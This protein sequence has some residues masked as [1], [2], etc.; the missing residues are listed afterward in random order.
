MRNFSIALLII[1]SCFIEVYAQKDST[2]QKIKFEGDFRFRI[3]QDWDSRN[4]DGSYRDDRSRLRYRARAGITYTQN[5]YHSFGLRLRTGNPKKQQ[6]PQLTLGAD[7]QE[8]GTLPIAFEKAY[9]Q[10]EKDFWSFWLGKNT[11]PFE[12][13]NELFWSD[14]VFP[15][16]AFL[17]RKFQ[18]NTNYLSHLDLRAGHFILAANGASFEEDAYL[19]AIQ[20]K[21][22]WWQKKISLFPAFY[23][24]RNIAYTPDGSANFDVDYNIFHLGSRFK[25]LSKPLLFLELDFLQ[26][27]ENYDL[28]SIPSPLQNQ[29]QGIIAAISVGELKNKGNWF[30]KL[31]YTQLERFSAVD[32]LAQN[33]WA[34]WDYSNLASPDGRLTNMEGIE[35]VSSFLVEKNLKLTMKYYW[36]DQLIATGVKR[37]TNQRIR[38]DLD[39]N[40]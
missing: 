1:V 16:G 29:R 6:D 4:P 39:I 32:Y 19:Q 31:T 22:E 25:L 34:R 13:N 10:Y 36:V 2:S 28:D 26:N 21:S 24:F 5:K 37:E 11:F 15:D 9:Y 33:D 35:F 23:H 14:N 27:I 20:I 17:K 18:I 3:E 40:F 7:N 30:F 38:F 12:K 8:S